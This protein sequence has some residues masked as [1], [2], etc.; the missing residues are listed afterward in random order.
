MQVVSDDV[1]IVTGM[2]RV[3]GTRD[4]TVYHAEGRVTFVLQKRGAAWQ[5]A[6][7]HRSAVPTN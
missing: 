6:H 1:V 4:G 7:F 3:S 5:I 2:D